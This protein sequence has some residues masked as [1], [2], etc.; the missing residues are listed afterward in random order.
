MVHVQEEQGQV[1]AQA[2]MASQFPGEH[3]IEMPAVGDAGEAIGGAQG[4]QLA[5]AFSQGGG[6]GLD[7]PGAP[8]HRPGQ[9][10]GAQAKQGVD[11]G[12]GGRQVAQDGRGVQPR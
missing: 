5:V 10:P 12:A 7:D 1:C 2:G 11:R 6:L 9:G 8:A 3:G 4:L